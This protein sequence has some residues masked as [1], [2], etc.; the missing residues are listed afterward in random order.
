MY[1]N[2]SRSVNA[3]AAAAAVIVHSRRW[4]TTNPTSILSV[5]EDLRWNVFCQRLRHHYFYFC[6]HLFHHQNTKRV[7]SWNCAPFHLWISLR[8]GVSG[9]FPHS[10]SLSC[11]PF[12]F[13]L[14]RSKIHCM[15]YLWIQYIVGA[16]SEQMMI[17]NETWV[18][19][20]TRMTKRKKKNQINSVYLPCTDELKS[21]ALMLSHTEQVNFFLFISLFNCVTS[22]LSVQIV[23]SLSVFPFRIAQ[24]AVL[25]LWLKIEIC[26]HLNRLEKQMGAQWNENKSNEQ[27]RLIFFVS[28]MLC[29]RYFSL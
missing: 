25:K 28:G 11:F 2:I 24:G 10:L 27:S 20:N 9:T 8:F 23:R 18:R 15:L 29:A 14:A 3:A 19:G 13:Q 22:D 26:L 12:L 4:N 5:G 21:L 16:F 17:T 6:R 1:S 7:D